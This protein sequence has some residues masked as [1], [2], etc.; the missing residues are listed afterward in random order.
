MLSGTSCRLSLRFCAVTDDLFEARGFVRLLCVHD[1]GA[2]EHG[3]REGH[4]ALN[5]RRQLGVFDA[6]S[7]AVCCV[8]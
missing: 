7:C 4:A 1:A 5:A 2:C 8:S 6:G 3:A